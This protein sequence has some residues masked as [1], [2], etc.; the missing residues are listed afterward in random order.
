MPWFRAHVAWGKA[1]QDGNVAAAICLLA[2]VLLLMASW[3]L[4][5]IQ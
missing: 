5:A 1:I 2:Y 3:W 4:A